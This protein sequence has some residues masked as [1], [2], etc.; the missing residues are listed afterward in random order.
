MLTMAERMDENLIAFD[1]VNVHKSSTNARR[2]I[3]Q[4]MRL[5]MENLFQSLTAQI[6]M[7]C[8]CSCSALFQSV[9]R[10]PIC[11][12]HQQCRLS[13]VSY[14]LVVKFVKMDD[15]A[16][17]FSGPIGFAGFCDGKDV[18]FFAA[19]KNHSDLV[20]ILANE[21]SCPVCPLFCHRWQI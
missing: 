7:F 21:P 18:F 1:H 8:V 3:A 16:S 5:E 13:V 9:S 20:K 17:F 19:G 6:N 15:L 11:L 2:S 12:C 10:D 4:I 14:S